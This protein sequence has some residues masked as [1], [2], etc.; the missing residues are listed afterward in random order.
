ME[1]AKYDAIIIGSGLGGLSC[2]AYLAKNGLKVLILEKHTTPGGY[3][4][5]FRRGVYTFDSTLHMIAGVGKGQDMYRFL[6]WCGVADEIE[7]LKLKHFARLVFPDHDLRVPNG[8]LEEVTVLLETSF[9]NEK[10]I[11]P[12]L[13][14][15]TKIH[16]D[17]RRFVLSEAPMWQQLPIFPFKYR[18]LFRML[19]KTAKQLLD[20]HIKDYKLKA[21]LLAN[22]GFFG[23]PPSRLNALSVYANITYWTDGAY[24]PKGGNQ[25]IPNAFAEFIKRNKGEIY[26][27]SQVTSI[28]TEKNQAIGVRTRKGEEFF[29]ENIISNASAPETFHTLIGDRRLPTKFL[30]KMKGM[31]P[32]TSGFMVYLGLDEEFKAKLNNTEDYEI[33]V[34]ETY[35]QDTDYE[36]ISQCET[37]KASYFITLHS[38]VDESLSPANR[39]VLSLT[40]GQ[41]YSHWKKFETDYKTGKKDEYNKEKDRLAGILIKR[42][43]K[44]ISGLSRHIEVI[45]SATPLTLERYTGN[46][47]GAFYGWANT[48]TQFTP[49][50]RMVNNPIKHL[51]LSSAWTFPGEG[52]ATTIACGYRTARHIIGRK[53][54]KY[55]KALKLSFVIIA[56]AV[57]ATLSLL[58][59]S[60]KKLFMS[61]LPKYP[62][63]DTRRLTKFF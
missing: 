59:V 28:I 23:L 60:C 50:D 17:T 9:P 22:Y 53:K 45:E 18:S 52:Q 33:F 11:R 10:G 38:N 37:E 55:R 20:K 4:T 63:C 62:C 48:T 49:M 29:A 43:E 36:W 56:V 34:S 13:R 47:N 58:L 57:I 3:A 51:H 21:I 40:Q 25:T 35:D 44:I 12:L 15:M 16:D 32:S 39:F 27:N 54:G 7:F 46:F 30:E 41:P 24:Y 8:N 2:G 19:K 61:Y 14:E 5:S 1:S 31:E 26:L 6:E 42:A